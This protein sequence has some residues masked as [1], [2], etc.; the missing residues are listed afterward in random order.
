MSTMASSPEL[1]TPV[2]RS[3]P[4]GSLVVLQQP[5]ELLA[6]SDV[7]AARHWELLYQLVPES[8]VRPLGVLVDNLLVEGALEVLR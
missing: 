1:T 6:G 4:R 7:A 5:A 3:L 2:P 8:L